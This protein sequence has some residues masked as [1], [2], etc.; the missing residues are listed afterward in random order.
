MSVANR[1]AR[2]YKRRHAKFDVERPAVSVAVVTGATGGIG[3]WIALGIARAGYQV[4]LVGRDRGR[5]EAV[6]AWIAGQCPGAATEIMLADLSSL[7]ETRGLAAAI[8]GRHPALQLLVNNAG[9]FRARRAET[10][11]GHELVCAVNHLSPFVLTRALEPALRAGAPSRIVTIGSSMSD[12]ARIDPANLEL[13]TGWSLTRAY[14][15]SK[16]AAMMTTMIFADRLAGSGVTANVVHPGT[17]A[18]GLVR[19]RGVIG[20]AWRLMAPFVLTGQQGAETP[21]YAAL[22]PELADV[23]GRY[24]KRRRAVPPNALVNNPALTQHVWRATEALVER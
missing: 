2:R 12:R 5:A 23:T 9:V 19:T 20:L 1:R 13:A 24:F 21:L 7:A 14:S 18:T 10:A 17:V 15:Q 3:R 22:A 4:V 11:E 6:Q 8:I 16:L